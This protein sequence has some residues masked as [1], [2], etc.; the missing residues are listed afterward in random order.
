MLNTPHFN[1]YFYDNVYEHNLNDKHKGLANEYSLLVRNMRDS[2]SAAVNPVELKNKL[3][4]Y[5]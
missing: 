1:E 3:S 2:S 4:R 5:T